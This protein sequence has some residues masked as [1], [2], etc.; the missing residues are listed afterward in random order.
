MIQTRGPSG[1]EP[2]DEGFWAASQRGRCGRSMS[3]RHSK[4]FRLHPLS[5][6]GPGTLARE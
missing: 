2:V 5:D 1:A 4:N 6:V 3:T